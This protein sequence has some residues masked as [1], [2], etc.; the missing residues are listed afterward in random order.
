MKTKKNEIKRKSRL[1]GK[2]KGKKRSKIMRGGSG[3]SGSNRLNW[4]V[5]DHRRDTSF[6]QSWRDNHNKTSYRKTIVYFF[7]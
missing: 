6:T 1:I 2:L 3:R 5:P 4:R 7:L